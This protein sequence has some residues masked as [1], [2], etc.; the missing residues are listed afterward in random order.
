M[1]KRQ[2]KKRDKK[3]KGIMK[4]LSSKDWEF[5]KLL[6]ESSP[7]EHYAITE[8]MKAF[9][10]KTLSA[11]DAEAFMYRKIEE[12]NNNNPVGEAV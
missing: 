2:R 8:V 12:Y 3:I 1:N 6:R 4:P 7:A 10:N 11:K 9:L 5:L